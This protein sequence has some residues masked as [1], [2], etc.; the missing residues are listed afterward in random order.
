MCKVVK[1]PMDLL[2]MGTFYKKDNGQKVD[3]ETRV[4]LQK[5]MPR[6]IEC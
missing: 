3:K 5:V 2:N 1:C 4:H 6:S